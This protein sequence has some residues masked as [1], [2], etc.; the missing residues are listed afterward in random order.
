MLEGL[1]DSLTR[2]RRLFL[3]GFLCQAVFGGAFLWRLTV[4]NISLTTFF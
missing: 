4:L 3:S 2:Q 1:V